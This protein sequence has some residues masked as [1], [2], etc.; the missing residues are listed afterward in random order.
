MVIYLGLNLV[1][2]PIFPLL[3]WFLF[4]SEN[5]WN[6]SNKKKHNWNFVFIRINIVRPVLG[7]FKSWETHSDV[8]VAFQCIPTICYTC[9]DLH[10]ISLFQTQY[11]HCRGQR[12]VIMIHGISPTDVFYYAIFDDLYGAVRFVLCGRT[13]V[14]NVHPVPWGGELSS[15]GVVC[16]SSVRFDAIIN[17]CLVFW[18]GIDGYILWHV[19]KKRC[20]LTYNK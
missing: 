3:V 16:I 7:Q 9:S 18:H 5:K 17:K 15:C 11:R 13:R 12:P 14:E 19:G 2:C 8:L 6:K 1:N 10:N 4:W 20:L